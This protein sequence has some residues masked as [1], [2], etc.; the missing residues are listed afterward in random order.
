LF[1]FRQTKE[2]ASRPSSSAPHTKF[3][4]VEHFFL[5]IAF[6]FPTTKENQWRSGERTQFPLTF[7][8]I[9]TKQTP[10]CP[11]LQVVRDSGWR[12]HLMEHANIISF[13]CAIFT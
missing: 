2:N 8:T 10:S 11:E 5:A 3:H 4:P 7:A 9:V 6:G 12:H 13:P 1:S